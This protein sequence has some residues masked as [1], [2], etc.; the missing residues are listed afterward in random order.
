[1]ATIIDAAFAALTSERLVLRRFRPEDLGTFV[2]YRSDP[3]TARYKNREAPYRPSQARPF[4]Q[5]LAA[6]H[7]DTRGRWSSSPSPC[8]E[9]IG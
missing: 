9:P 6:V 3:G 1:M 2:A 8:A 5:E 7:P 4:L